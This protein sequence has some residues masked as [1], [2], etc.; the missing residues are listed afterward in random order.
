MSQ[1][2]NGEISHSNLVSTDLS[3]I[4]AICPSISYTKIV[5]ML[6]CEMW[7]GQR[8]T[9]LRS[10]HPETDD[11]SLEI[12]WTDQSDE[13]FPRGKRLEFQAKQTMWSCSLNWWR[14]TVPGSRVGDWESTA[15]KCHA[16]E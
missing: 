14:E 1:M 13:T 3:G 4:L 15:T 5:A 8:L 7:H 2:L 12:H 10:L 11:R 6:S 9:K 16:V